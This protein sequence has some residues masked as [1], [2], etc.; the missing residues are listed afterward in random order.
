MLPG[1]VYIEVASVSIASQPGGSYE[2]VA[3]KVPFETRLMQQNKIRTTV[4]VDKGRKCF[5]CHDIQF[6]ANN[7]YDSKKKIYK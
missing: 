1:V 2:T 3:W 7:R 5:S 6:D 4:Y